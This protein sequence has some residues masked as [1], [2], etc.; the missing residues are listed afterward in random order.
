MSLLHCPDAEAFERGNYLRAPADVA[1]MTLLLR[2]RI[3][4]LAWWLVGVVFLLDLGAS[5]RR[6]DRAARTSSSCCSAPGRLGPETCCTSPHSRP[7]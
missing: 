4:L 7:F 5:R 3:D 1:P 6:R 2:R